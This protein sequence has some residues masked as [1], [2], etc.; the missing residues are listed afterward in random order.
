MIFVVLVLFLNLKS[1]FLNPFPLQA[2]ASSSQKSVAI[3][4]S[5]GI[6]RVTIHGYTSPNS[7]VELNSP[8]VFAVTYSNDTGEFVFDK[9]ILPKNPSDLCLTSINVAQIRTTPVCIPPPP[10]TNYHTNIGPILLPPTVALDTS[11]IK[12]N[13]TAIISVLAIPNSTVDIYFFQNSHHASIFPSALAFSLPKISTTTSADGTYSLSLPTTYSS[14][15]RVYAS[16]FYQEFASPKS[17]TLLY[18]L[19]SLWYLFWIANQ[20]QIISFIFLTLIIGI[21]I[22][23]IYSKQYGPKPRSTV[24]K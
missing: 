11:T 15:Y 12:P 23:L 22:Y 16:V 18:K 7:R 6:N 14:D 20:Y 8:R 13:S 2:I 17:N 5:I 4:A 10:S 21:I 9:T 24:S 1:Y 19:P 3:S